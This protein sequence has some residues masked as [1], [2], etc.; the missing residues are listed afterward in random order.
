MP[1]QCHRLLTG[2]PSTRRPRGLSTNQRRHHRYEL[3]TSIPALVHQLHTILHPRLTNIFKS[4]FMGLALQF[5]PGAM[6]VDHGGRCWQM[7]KRGV[8]NPARRVNPLPSPWIPSHLPVGTC[9][10]CWHHFLVLVRVIRVGSP[11]G[12]VD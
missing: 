6:P 9:Q 1:L 7:T 12:R 4:S 3:G 10:N 8:C 11:Y 5:I 2:C